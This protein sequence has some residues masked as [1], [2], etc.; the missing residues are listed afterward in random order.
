[1]AAARGVT[2]SVASEDIDCDGEACQD[3]DLVA[4]FPG[5]ATGFAGTAAIYLER[6][7]LLKEAE[8]S[9]AAAASAV[10][11]N[12]YTIPDD[13]NDEDVVDGEGG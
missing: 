7:A 13:T 8:A 1:M 2:A 3:A 11:L 9:A 6:E 12:V 4:T 10:V 5:F